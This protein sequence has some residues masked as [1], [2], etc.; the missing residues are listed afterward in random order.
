MTPE[1]VIRTYSDIVYR[2]AFARAGTKADA[3][4]IYQ[5]VF[6]RYIRKAP[7]FREEEHAK[8]WFIKVT[9]NCS[10][11]SLPSAPTSRTM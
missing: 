10:R 9:V 5:E 3:D 7:V 6:L 1:G 8:A 4:D 11:I 2:I